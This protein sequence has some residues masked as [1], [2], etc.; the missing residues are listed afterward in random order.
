MGGCIS[1]KQL[2]IPPEAMTQIRQI[3]NSQ[4]TQSLMD[5]Y[6]F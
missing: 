4:Y 1:Q 5:K 6:K 2:Q 3:R